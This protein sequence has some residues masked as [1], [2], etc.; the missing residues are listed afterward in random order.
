LGYWPVPVSFL[1]RHLRH[2][3]GNN[4]TEA[5]TTGETLGQLII[6]SQTAFPDLLAG[7]I[8]Q[9]VWLRLL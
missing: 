9:A 6:N 3:A 4:P 2:D 5:V 7:M 8:E 1:T